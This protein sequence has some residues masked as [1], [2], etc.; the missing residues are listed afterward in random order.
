MPQWQGEELLGKRLLVLT[1]QGYGD[2]IQFVRFVPLLARRG[3][4]IVV[5]AS[6]EMQT[7]TATLEGVS[8]VISQVEDAWNCG[9]DYWTF[10]GTLPLRLGVGAGR[11]PAAVPYLRTDPARAQAWRE[12]LSPYPGALKVGLVW[13]GR[14]THGNDWRR[15]I[16]VAC[17]APLAGVPGAVF[18]T[19]QT[20]ERANDAGT[21]PA[22]MAV[23]ACGDEL[24]DFADTAALLGELDLLI[25]ADTAPAH[26]AGALARPVWNLL[27]FQPDWRWR[28]DTDVSR[29]YP[30]MRLFR[31]QHAGDWDGVVERVAAELTR[32]AADRAGPGSQS[33]SG[34]A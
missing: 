12:R 13:A 21:L 25:S 1:E 32:L 30:T 23:I 34:L 16:P 8:H 27:P 2:H 33:S 24:K 17:L 31:Q 20:G 29:W 9:C 22:G 3:V 10:V 5:G 28:L 19:L 4:D 11:V 14:P 26:L 7:L 6:P 15:S 18:V